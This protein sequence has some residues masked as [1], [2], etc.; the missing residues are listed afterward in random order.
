MLQ[1]MWARVRYW[2]RRLMG[3]CTSCGLERHRH[4][5]HLCLHCRRDPYRCHRC[6]KREYAAE[7]YGTRPHV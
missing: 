1:H 6:L 5:S 3:R 4:V 7:L 2:V